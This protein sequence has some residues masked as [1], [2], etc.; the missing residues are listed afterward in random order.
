MCIG[1]KIVVSICA[2]YVGNIFQSQNFEVSNYDRV[3]SRNVCRSL[4]KTSVMLPGFKKHCDESTVH[5]SDYPD[6]KFH[7]HHSPGSKVVAPGQTGRHD[8][9]NGHVSAT[10][11]L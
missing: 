8:K 3:A 4:R 7:T 6:I 1:R 5:Q 2:I 9:V 10:L 11:S